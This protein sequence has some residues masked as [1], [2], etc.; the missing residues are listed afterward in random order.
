[1]LQEQG[2]FGVGQFNLFNCLSLKYET[3]VSE[4]VRLWRRPWGM[5]QR[6]ADL[7]LRDHVTTEAEF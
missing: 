5:L 6:A 2:V 1:M 3:K 4:I 7:R